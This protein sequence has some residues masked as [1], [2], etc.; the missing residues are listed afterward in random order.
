MKNTHSCRIGVP[1]EWDG[2]SAA[3]CLGHD[4]TLCPTVSHSGFSN[5][6]GAKVPLP[7]L[8]GDVGPGNLCRDDGACASQV[9]ES[10]SENDTGV[11]RHGLS[12]STDDPPTISESG[13]TCFQNSCCSAKCLDATEEDAANNPADE[14]LKDAPIK[15]WDKAAI[16]KKW[17]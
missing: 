4:A 11:Q 8:C 6:V 7:R 5:D 1:P 16:P 3:K 15:S 14:L 10:S 2:E 17:N 12:P 9:A 13:R